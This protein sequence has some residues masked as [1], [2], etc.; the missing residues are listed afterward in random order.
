MQHERAFLHCRQ[1]WK[2]RTFPEY[3][4]CLIA[5]N[6]LLKNK[7]AFIY[8]LTYSYY[9]FY[10]APFDYFSKSH[11]TA[12]HLNVIDLNSHIFPGSASAIIRFL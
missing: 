8:C 6:L 9:L 1:H 2:F 4:F 7:Y 5:K 10:P 12:S 11:R 3:S